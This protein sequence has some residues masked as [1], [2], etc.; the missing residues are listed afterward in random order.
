[1]CAGFSE[2][3]Q[4]PRSIVDVQARDMM[5]SARVLEA[6]RTQLAVDAIAPEC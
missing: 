4:L 2:V 1:L 6:R 5:L 3:A